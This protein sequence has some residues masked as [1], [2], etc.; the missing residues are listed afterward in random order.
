ML[1]QKPPPARQVAALLAVLYK[2]LGKRK[3]IK[4]P[5]EIKSWQELLALEKLP[6]K[7]KLIT[8]HF[9]YWGTL[10]QLEQ[11]GDII[12]ATIGTSD[13]PTDTLQLTRKDFH[14]DNHEND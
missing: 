2:P 8:R 4:M 6:Q 14:G 11:S 5:R 1:T 7:I 12:I 13:Q 9:M 3:K 10:Y